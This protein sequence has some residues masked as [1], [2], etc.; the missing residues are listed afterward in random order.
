[1]AVFELLHM[2]K[3]VVLCIYCCDVSIDVIK[4]Q[5]EICNMQRRKR[6]LK[7]SCFIVIGK[8]CPRRKDFFLVFLPPGTTE[9]G[10]NLVHGFSD[11]NK[12]LEVLDLWESSCS[13]NAVIVVLYQNNGCHGRYRFCS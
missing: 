4:N 7:Q 3:K 12:D 8:F 6:R 11:Q 5:K 2:S 1:M 10:L 9:Q 13:G